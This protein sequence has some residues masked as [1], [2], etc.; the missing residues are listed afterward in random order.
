MALPALAQ[1]GHPTV[2]QHHQRQDGLFQGGTMVF[3]STMGADAHVR[4]A[5][6]SG[7]T[8]ERNARRV[9][10]IQALIHPCWDTHRTG[11]LTQEA[12]PPLGGDLIEAAAEVAAVE[13]VRVNARAP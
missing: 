11:K 6:G 3:G 9:E 2:L 12:L 4:I 1:Q 10:L 13:H 7:R 8:A 5:L